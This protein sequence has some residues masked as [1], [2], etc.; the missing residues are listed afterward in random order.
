MK[1]PAWILLP[2]ALILTFSTVIVISGVGNTHLPNV[3]VRRITLSDTAQQRVF[4]QTGASAESY[5]VRLWSTCTRSAPDEPYVCPKKLSLGY[6]FNFTDVLGYPS[7]ITDLPQDSQT[8]AQ[9]INNLDAEVAK[10]QICSLLYKYLMLMMIISRLTVIVLI[11]PLRLAHMRIASALSQNN[12]LAIRTSFFTLR[13]F[14]SVAYIV[15]FV[16]AHLLCAV[17]VALYFF[18]IYNP[19]TNGSDTASEQGLGPVVTLFNFLVMVLTYAELYPA[20]VYMYKLPSIRPGKPKL[21]IMDSEMTLQGTMSSDTYCATSE[22]ELKVLEKTTPS[23]HTVRSL[24]SCTTVASKTRTATTTSVISEL[25][26][27]VHSSD[28]PSSI[29]EVSTTHPSEFSSMR[30]VVFLPHPNLP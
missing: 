20:I 28:V 17:A 3:Y 7:N 27:L 8:R 4:N 14:F 29:S 25:P 15:T 16:T 5:A 26:S 18:H 30:S 1:S 23:V 12:M 10:F 22:V 6:F 11:I 2:S 24:Q 13:A 21:R 19:Y 9:Q